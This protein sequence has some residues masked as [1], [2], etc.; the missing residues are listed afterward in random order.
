M[1]RRTD[2]RVAGVTFLLYIA[3]GI[4]SLVLSSQAT[5]GEGIAAR[6][7]TIAQHQTDLRLTVLLGLLTSFTALVLGVT[8]W[9]LTRDQDPDLAM[10]AMA[11]RVL[12]AIVDPIP[13]MGL[14]WLASATDARALDPDASH[15]LAAFL[16]RGGAWSPGA[17]FFAV[18]STIF[19]WLLLRGRMIPV[20]LASLGVVASALL[21]VIL[22]LQLTGFA[23]SINWLGAITWVIWFPMLV[24]E[25]WL[26]LWLILKGAAPPKPRPSIGAAAATGGARYGPV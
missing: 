18:G 8:L 7:A 19:A 15:A 23:G 6:L 16:L 20:P 3:A 17:L 21:V 5:R 22:P 4:T 12:E 24:F 13:S 11:C 10:L 2:A 26:A 9:A 25:V 1:T 14:L